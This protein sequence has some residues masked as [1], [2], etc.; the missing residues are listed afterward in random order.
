MDCEFCS[1]KGR[2]RYAAPERM[3]ESIRV[4][5]E[6][7][8]ARHFF[9]V[10]DLFGQQRAETL[11]FCRMLRDYQKDAKRRL[12][13][14]VQIRLDKAGDTEL[15]GAMREA[16]IDTVAIGYESPIAEELEAMKKHLKPEDMI[17]LTKVFRKFGFLVHGMFI[18]GYPLEEGIK[19]HLT[20]AERVRRFRQFIRRAGVD[21]L[22][23]LLP[24]PMPG[25]ELRR[26]LNEQH[27]IYPKSKIGWEFY[28]G[29]F[30]LFRP[31]PPMSPEEMHASIRQIMGKFYSFRSMFKV[32][33]N[34]FMFPALV[35]FLRDIR[36]GWW[37]WYRCWRNEIVRFGGWLLIQSWICDFKRSAFLEKL[38]RMTLD[39]T[40][41]G[42]R[43]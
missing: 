22:Q 23:V 31:D 32:G 11:C 7:R 20:A 29:N 35:F 4:L 34:V 41:S 18:F 38:D 10:D 21:T 13:F 8:H 9:I 19:V 26:R 6:T 43:R 3:L 30:P 2:P 37:W 39:R 25:T 28:D 17:S 24:I 12:R 36:R 5:V 42:G 33:L 1:V 40:T 27:R 16:G 15:L 14:T